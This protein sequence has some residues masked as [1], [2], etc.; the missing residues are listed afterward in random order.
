MA[1]LHV[2]VKT[3]N[4]AKA[5]FFVAVATF[6]GG[7]VSGLMAAPDSGAASRRR[8]A[9]KAQAQRHLLGDHLTSIEKQLGALERDLQLLGRRFKEQLNIE[10]VDTEDIAWDVASDEVTRELRGMPRK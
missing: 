3:M 2:S 1:H 9:E 4:N 8:I 7:F 6:A 5:L 10:A